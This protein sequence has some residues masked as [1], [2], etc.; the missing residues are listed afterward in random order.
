MRQVE[1][2]H[3]VKARPHP[4]PLP[5]ERENRSQR[6]GDAEAPVCRTLVSTIDQKVETGRAPSELHETRDGCSLSLGERVR[7]RASVIKLTSLSPDLGWP[8]GPGV[9]G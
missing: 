2:K 3:D 5:Q 6:S 7:V 4:G 8:H 9:I 1:E